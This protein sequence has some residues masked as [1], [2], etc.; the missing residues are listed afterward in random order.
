MD[1]GL[2]RLRGTRVWF[3]YERDVDGPQTATR[4]LKG[5]FQEKGL[6]IEESAE[7]ATLGIWTQSADERLRFIF[8]VVDLWNPQKYICHECGPRELTAAIMT[9]T[10][11]LLLLTNKKAVSRRASD[12]LN[13]T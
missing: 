5:K 12:L 9:A 6:Q 10:C 11:K 7:G 4:L 8:V 13:T 2:S 1:N 3:E